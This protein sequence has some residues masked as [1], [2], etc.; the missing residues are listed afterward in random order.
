LIGGKGADVLVGGAGN[1]T[2]KG[3]PG[4]D[5]FVIGNEVTGQDTIMD[6]KK[7]DILQI[8]DRN[9]DGQ[10]TVAPD[11]DVASIVHDTLNNQIIVTMSNGDTVTLDNIK[12]DK[13]NLTEAGDG[14][15]TLQ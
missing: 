12:N 15:F 1:D 8:Q 4:S 10:V 13:L 9:G 7:E 6:F 3:G 5:T 2:M 11:G 14:T